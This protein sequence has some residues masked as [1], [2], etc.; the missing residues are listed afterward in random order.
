MKRRLTLFIILCTIIALSATAVIV[1]AANGA[2]DT[3]TQDPALNKPQEIPDPFFTNSDAS[4]HK[5]FRR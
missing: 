3:A 5:A 2:F 1:A 4:L